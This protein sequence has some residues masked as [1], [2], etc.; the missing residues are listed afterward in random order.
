MDL[1][2]DGL[3]AVQ[4]LRIGG[5]GT[6]D[7]LFQKTDSLLLLLEVI[8]KNKASLQLGPGNY[9]Y[10]QLQTLMFILLTLLT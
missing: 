1:V 8:I 5:L 4:S 2:T 9:V 7:G 10:C 6:E 3:Q